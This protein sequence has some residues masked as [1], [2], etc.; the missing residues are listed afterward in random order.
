MTME[1]QEFYLAVVR[2]L[3]EDFPEWR[4]PVYEGGDEAS[5][6]GS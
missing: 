3:S 1:L 4:L 5:P 2:G 6:N